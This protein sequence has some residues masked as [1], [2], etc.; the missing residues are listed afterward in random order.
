M[1]VPFANG[2]DNAILAK[3]RTLIAGREGGTCGAPATMPCPR[4]TEA[5]FAA[6]T[7]TTPLLSFM[8]GVQIGL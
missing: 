7:K 5:E 3:N 2:P 1:M 8:I 6:S 4:I